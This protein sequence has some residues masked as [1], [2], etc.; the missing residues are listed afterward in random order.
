M[1]GVYLP[2]SSS[3]LVPPGSSPHAR[4]LLHGV[5]AAGHAD[6]IIPACA[7]FT[8]WPGS[9]RHWPGDHPRMR[10]VYF[11]MIESTD[12]ASGSSPHT[13][14]LL[15]ASSVMVMVAR[16]IPAHAG[17]T[18]RYPYWTPG[19]RDHPRTRGVYCA[20]VEHV[21]ID[22]GSSPH[23]RGLPGIRRRGLDDRGIIPAR[24]GF[25]FSGR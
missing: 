13:R 24:A 22:D 1:R 12:V 14:G 6:R 18:P 9:G 3:M 19:S 20:P 15:P 5:E 11:F 17:F 21:G 7:G 16:I 8:R 2:A 25:T 23:A 10:G 4:G